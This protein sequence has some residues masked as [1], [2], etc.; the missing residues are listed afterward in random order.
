MTY[1]TV[2]KNT[3]LSNLTTPNIIPGPIGFGHG[4]NIAVDGSS[5]ANAQQNTSQSLPVSVVSFSSGTFFIAKSDPNADLLLSWGVPGQKYY[6]GDSSSKNN[7]VPATNF[8]VTAMREDGT[9]YYADTDI[10]NTLPTPTCSAV[11]CVNYV[12]YAAAAITQKFSG[13]AN[14]APFAAPP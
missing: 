12:A 11:P 8:I 1:I 6:F 10:G 5:I 4:V 2:C 7:S 13:P 3:I 14:L 9:N